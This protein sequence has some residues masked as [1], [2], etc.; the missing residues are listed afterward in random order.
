MRMKAK[1]INSILFTSNLVIYN[2]NNC[3]HFFLNL[4]SNI[5]IKQ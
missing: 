4:K 5:I 2:L 1:V 3:I